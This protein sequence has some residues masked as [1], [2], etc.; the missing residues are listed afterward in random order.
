MKNFIKKSTSKLKKAWESRGDMDWRTMPRY[1]RKP[2]EKQQQESLPT[3][4]R[5]DKFETRENYYHS[6]QSCEMS[7]RRTRHSKE[8]DRVLL[9]IV[10]THNNRRSQGARC[11]ST[12]Q[13][14]QLPYP[15]GRSWSRSKITEERQ[16]GRSGQHS[17][18]AG[19]GRSRGHDRCCSSSEIRSGRQESGQ[20]LGLSPWSSLFQR[21]ATYNYAQTAVP[22]AW[23]VIQVRSC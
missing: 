11:P 12:N 3:C 9:W 13:Q 8:V 23:S 22:S 20:H 1:R 10:Y 5:T 15:A 21:K 16:V 14:W 7:H 19:P 6:R 18:G 17:I 2:A 4:E